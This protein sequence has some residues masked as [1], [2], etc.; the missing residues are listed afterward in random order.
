MYS[1]TVLEAKY[2]HCDDRMKGAE[3]KDECSIIWTVNDIYKVRNLKEEQHWLPGRQ[4]LIW[5]GAT[6][7]SLESCSEAV[8]STNQTSCACAIMDFRNCI[9]ILQFLKDIF[10]IFCNYAVSPMNGIGTFAVCIYT[11]KQPCILLNKIISCNWWYLTSPSNVLKK[12]PI[13][14]SACKS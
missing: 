13:C 10:K 7:D 3:W 9:L 2:S 12:E 4:G 14:K 11:C 1:G 6:C 5:I 8:S